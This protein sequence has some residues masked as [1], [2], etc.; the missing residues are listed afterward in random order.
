MSV[1]VADPADVVRQRLV[2]R[3]RES[4]LDV[5]AEATSL[6]EMSALAARMQP[7][8]I[9]TDVVFPDG[10]G[11]AIVEAARRSAPRAVVVILTNAVHYRQ[12]CLANGVD[13]FLDKST[14]FDEVA[15]ALRRPRT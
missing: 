7:D 2:V 1:L 14:D 9:V 8:A 13:G 11:L 6:A 15:P 12:A 3:L 5:V 4:G 10:R